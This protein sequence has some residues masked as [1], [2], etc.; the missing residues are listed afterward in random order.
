MSLVISAIIFAVF[1]LNVSMGAFGSGVFLSDVQEM[2]VLLISTAF[3][4]AGIL[5]KEAD[6]KSSHK[7]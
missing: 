3:F 2:I 5:K 4:V 1:G 7:N 6:E